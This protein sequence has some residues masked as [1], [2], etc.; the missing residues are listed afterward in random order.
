MDYKDKA[1]LPMKE[2][3]SYFHGG[4]HELFY[5]GIGMAGHRG[6]VFPD[7]YRTDSTGVW[8][9]AGPPGT[10]G[11]TVFKSA[12]VLLEFLTKWHSNCVCL[13]RELYARRQSYG[14]TVNFR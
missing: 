10:N 2:V 11:L 7:L 6:S 5:P 12:I 8:L 13:A 1:N 4:W 14:Q 9:P 3:T